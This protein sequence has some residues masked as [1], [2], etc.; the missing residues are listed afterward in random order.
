MSG[1]HQTVAGAGRLIAISICRDR[2][3][4]AIWVG[5]IVTMVWVSALSIKGLFPTQAK[6]DAAAIASSNPAVVAFNGPA[7]ALDTIGGEIVFQ[8][9][10]PG[11][12]TVGLMTLLMVLRLTRRE[13]ES[14]RLELVRSLPVGRRAPLVAAGAVGFGASIAAA[15]GSTV[16]LLATGQ[17]AV[18]SIAF[19][20]EVGVVGGVF[21]GIALV[22]AQITENSRLASGMAGAAL[23]ASFVIRAIGDMRD[24]W[25][26]WLSPIGWAQQ[27][28]P[29]AGE[30]WWTLA[31]DAVAIAALSAV[32]MVLLDRRDLG[33]GLI[34]SRPGPAVAGAD[35]GSPLALAF[36]L[37]RGS[38]IGWS[39][40][41]AAAGA[42]YGLIT[43]AI[44]GFVRDNPDMADF[45]A[46]TGS[47]SLIDSYLAT[48]THVTALIATAAAVQSILRL[49]SEETAM[50]AE[51]LL[52]TAVSRSSWAWSYLW[53]ALATSVAVLAALG[54][55]LGLS[56][57]AV[58]GQWSIVGSVLIGS[59]IHLP[60][61]G[62]AIG[63][64]LALSGRLPNLAVGA[65]ALVAGGLVV[66]LF[67]PVL[68][69]PRWTLDLS[70]FEHV[71]LF[72]AQSVRALPLVVLVL[73]GMVLAAIGIDGLRRRD[74][75]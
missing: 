44:A 48:S 21:T 54:L 51:P 18:G 47:A 17:A 1:R 60:A 58:S 61:M 10:A 32:A 15:V 71:P 2:I 38:I 64:A 45:L 75:G 26:S 73:V 12:T 20:L 9:G 56:T 42:T 69:L 59:F 28:R 30:R 49:R 66:A 43:N 70:P 36:R 22:A 57:A 3:R 14:G 8:I 67:G 53:V 11:L 7:N 34:S 65:W 16:A 31:L 13:E 50:R 63:F 46:S 33:S 24:S 68:R 23:A 27:L 5:A 29:F 6:L 35:L 41:I 19:G 4:I 40:G 37:Q 74:I 62:F 55:G 25:L 39:M 72:P 52:A